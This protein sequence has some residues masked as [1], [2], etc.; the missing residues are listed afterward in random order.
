MKK[1]W[2]FS[3][4]I[5]E[6]ISYVLFFCFIMMNLRF[7]SLHFF[8]RA[9]LFLPMTVFGVLYL[10]IDV[11]L[12]LVMKNKMRILYIFYEFVT[13][14]LLVY[15]N[16]KIFYYGFFI[17]LLSHFIQ[18]TF[19]IYFVNKIYVMKDVK[20]YSKFFAQTFEDVKKKVLLLKGFSSIFPV[21]KK[22]RLV[23]ESSHQGAI[24]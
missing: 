19:R 6:F 22:R 8:E 13:I 14:F 4:N 15:F 1:K 23:K 21:N 12:F 3:L 24:S 16:L 11:F 7:G 2:N 10:S 20:R 17:L 5:I 18:D 9:L